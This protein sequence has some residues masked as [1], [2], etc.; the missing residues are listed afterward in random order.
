[1]NR[2]P[3]W[4]YAIIVIVLLVGLIY[5]LPN[6]FGE[7]PAVQ[8]SA[9]KSTVKVD[10]S[11]RTRVEAA[12]KAAN[13]QPDM[14]TLDGTSVRARFVT[15]DDQLKARDVLQHALVP[16]ASDP[17]YVVALNLVSRSPNWLKA[18]H[19]YPMYLGLD[20]RGGVHFMLQVDM[21]GALDKKAETM[22][23]DLRTALRDKGVRGTSVSRNG[24]T[25]EVRMRDQ[26]AVEATQR[27]I[28]DQLPDLAATVSQDGSEWK[29][30]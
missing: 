11:T 29:L 18:L 12:L 23:S 8:V 4:K 13:L 17:P 24:Q 22:A 7:A 27:I 5:A 14:L 10:D 16:D 21:K 28:Q 15:T 1:M 20:L 25:V 3:V 30:T 6:F 2:Y 19:A 26:A 9:A